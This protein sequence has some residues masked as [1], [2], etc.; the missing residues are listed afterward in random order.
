MLSGKSLLITISLH[1]EETRKKPLQD[2]ALAPIGRFITWM[3]M[4]VQISYGSV[5]WY[6][7]FKRFASCLIAIVSNPLT[8]LQK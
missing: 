5:V 1:R 3:S 2:W 4:L 7:I 8:S 6:F